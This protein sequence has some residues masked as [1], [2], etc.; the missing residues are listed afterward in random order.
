MR[1]FFLGW[2]FPESNIHKKNNYG[3]Q[4]VHES[5]IISQ[6][7]KIYH[8]FLDLSLRIFAITNNM[9]PSK[10]L[11]VNLMIS[12]H[13]FIGVKFGWIKRIVYKDADKLTNNSENI[14]N[15]VGDSKFMYLD[16]R[17]AKILCLSNYLPAIEQPA[18]LAS[19][20]SGPAGEYNNQTIKHGYKLN[21]KK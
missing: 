5:N 4:R 2:F 12:S 1:R 20:R 16:S 15:Q 21:G 3:K 17:Y 7:I 9:I 13:D 14:T 6:L 19:L 18:S 8:C 10:N 11:Y